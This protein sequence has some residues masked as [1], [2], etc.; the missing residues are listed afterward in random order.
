MKKQSRRCSGKLLRQ[1]Q[2]TCE[3]SA[4]YPTLMRSQ[5]KHDDDL[6]DQG[7]RPLRQNYL[8]GSHLCSGAIEDCFN[9]FL[10][11]IWLT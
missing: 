2:V 7:H 8:G 9:P 11:K 3:N 1:R 5:R 4:D 6:I 10:T